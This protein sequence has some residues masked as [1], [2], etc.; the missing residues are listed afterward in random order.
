MSKKI[1]RFPLNTAG[2]DFIIGDVHG[3]F[4]LVLSGMARG[5]FSPHI[6]A[7]M[8]LEAVEPPTLMR[9]VMADPTGVAVMS[10]VDAKPPS[11]SWHLYLLECRGGSLYAGITNNLDARLK[12]HREGKGAKYTRSHPPVRL[13]ASKAYPDRSTASR[14]EW[15]IKQLPKGKKASF[16]SAQCG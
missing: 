13:V 9:L 14:A 3:A 12:A 11:L 2:R 10:G 7:K 5:G 16:L 15:A 6:K 4:D 1:A 8:K